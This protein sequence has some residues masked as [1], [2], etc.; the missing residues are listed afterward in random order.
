MAEDDQ[1]EKES[2]DDPENFHTTAGDEDFLLEKYLPFEVP[3]RNTLSKLGW[4]VQ[5]ILFVLSVTILIIAAKIKPTDIQCAKQLSP[6][7]K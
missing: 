2:L 3:Q 6:Y 1:L 7:C 5:G 4:V